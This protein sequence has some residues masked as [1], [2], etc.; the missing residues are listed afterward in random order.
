MIP[1]TTAI[2]KL[3]RYV[4]EIQGHMRLRSSGD[5]HEIR[6]QYFSLLWYR[7]IK[8]LQTEGKEAVPA[9]IDLM[10]SYYLTKD[11]WDAMFE[12]G[13]GPMDMD[14]MKI[15]SQAKSTFT[16]VYNQQA[17]PL[18]YM[19]ASQIVAPKKKD[20]ERPDLEEALDES[21]SGA[22]EG[23][24]QAV[25]DEDEPLDLKKDKYVK[26]PKKKTKAKATG[27]KGKGKRKGKK[28]ESEDDGDIDGESEEFDK[29]KKA[30]GRADGAKG[31]PKK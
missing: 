8:Q 16:R 20:K 3:I 7:L 27:G 22:S 15:D 18:P 30:K 31:R 14:G 9:M 6:Q 12:L 25:L 4:K 11:D 21:D 26:A 29:P 19:K 23:E 13:I 24:D 28:E 10:D 5:R 2:D 1:L 17:H